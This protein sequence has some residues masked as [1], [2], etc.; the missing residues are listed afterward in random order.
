MPQKFGGANGLSV[1]QPTVVSPLYVVFRV[2]KLYA[3][4][5]CYTFKSHLVLAI[6]L[7]IVVLN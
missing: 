1:P 4:S 7:F 5:G 2:I 6:C 3:S